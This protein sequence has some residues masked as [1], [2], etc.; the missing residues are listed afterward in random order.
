MS[1]ALLASHIAKIHRH[2]TQTPVLVTPECWSLQ[3]DFYVALAA[4]L[5]ALRRCPVQL[6]WYRGGPG[7]F[8]FLSDWRAQRAAA[9]INR[10]LAARLQPCGVSAAI[11]VTAAISR[12]AAE[13]RTWLI[14]ICSDGLELPAWTTSIQL[15]AAPHQIADK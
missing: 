5:A 10:C 8:S 12:L 13:P 6:D 3:P 9:K 1:L 4:E 7:A 14:G 15:A 2:G 11:Q